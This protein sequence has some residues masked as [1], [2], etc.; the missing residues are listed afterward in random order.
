MR[1]SGSNGN[2]RQ[3]ILW[4]DKGDFHENELKVLGACSINGNAITVC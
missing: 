3:T 2:K 4:N 1:D